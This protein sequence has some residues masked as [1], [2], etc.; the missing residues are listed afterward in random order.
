MRRRRNPFAT[1]PNPFG[2]APGRFDSSAPIR[3]RTRWVGRLLALLIVLAGLG[4]GIAVILNQSSGQGGGPNPAAPSLQPRP[5]APAAVPG[6]VAVTDGKATIAYDVPAD[7]HVS[8]AGDGGTLSTG[9]WRLPVTML[10]SYL[11]GYCEPAPNSFRAESGAATVP[12]AD[13]TAAATDT[14]RHVADAIFGTNAA[15]TVTLNQPT[16][17]TAHG[18]TGTLVTARVTVHQPDRCAPPSGLVD[19]YAVPNPARHE[20]LV[21]IAYADQ[22]FTGAISQHDL[23]T[24]VTSIRPLP[25]H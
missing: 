20:S 1:G 22:Q 5:S 24:I 16:T 2:G 17:I 11:D 15:P 6:W 25:A 8:Y 12:D 23:D 7:W 18:R 4:V 21:V 3:P 13:A 14:A 9:D 19:V 10:A